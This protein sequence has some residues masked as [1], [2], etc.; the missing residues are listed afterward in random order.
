M[1]KNSNIETNNSRLDEPKF[2]DSDN[3]KVEIGKLASWSVSSAKPGSG[4]EQLRDNNAET[5]WQSDA[6]QP[7]NITIQFP[8]KCFIENILLYCN[9][10]LDESYTPQKISIKAGTLLHDL[11]EIITTEL[12]EPI[13]WIN[14]PLCLSNGGPLKA[15]L[16]QISILS[17]LKNGRDTHIRQIKVYGKKIS[18]E[19]FTQYPKFKSSE[20]SYFETIR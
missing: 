19:N 15:N 4:V 6:Q 3:N 11:Q 20:S 5:Y 2:D 14:I 1:I 18:I 12:E 13:G 16:L 17:N 8:K 10:K 7:H 9:Y